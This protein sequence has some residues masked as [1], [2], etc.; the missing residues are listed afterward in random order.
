MSAGLLASTVTPGMTPPWSSLTTP[1][2]PP[3]PR[4]PCA[5]ATVGSSET[6]TTATFTNRPIIMNASETSG[7]TKDWLA[8]LAY[9][10]GAGARTPRGAVANE[11]LDAPG[12]VHL[13]GVDIAVRIHAHDMRPVELPDLPAA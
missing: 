7:S 10:V 12:G 6:T 4:E 3:R 11:L 9:L 5:R 2:M 8:I 1:A 13:A